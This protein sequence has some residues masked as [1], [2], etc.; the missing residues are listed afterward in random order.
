MRDEEEIEIDL[1]YV[2]YLIELGCVIQ[3]NTTSLLGNSSEMHH[4][5]A[6]ELMD[7]QLV[8]LIATDTHSPNGGRSPH[9]K[10][11][12]DYLNN[13]GY[14]EKYIELLTYENPNRI[15]QNKPILKPKFKNKSYFHKILRCLK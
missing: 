8:H 1:D 7:H 2:C 14:Q 5:N 12:Y 11:C 15:L 3:V 6:M 10:E 9:M 13:Q 4:E